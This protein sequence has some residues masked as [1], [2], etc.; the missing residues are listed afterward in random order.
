MRLVQSIPSKSYRLVQFGKS[1][2]YRLVQLIIVINWKSVFYKKIKIDDF[3][4]GATM[5]CRNLTLVMMQG[6]QRDIQVG[7]YTVRCVPVT[8]WLLRNSHVETRH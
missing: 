6:E 8:D 5:L 1:K 7:E 3:L 4:K 2:I